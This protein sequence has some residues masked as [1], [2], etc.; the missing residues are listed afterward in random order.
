MAQAPAPSTP[1]VTD[2]VRVTVGTPYHVT[3]E[4]AASRKRL[5]R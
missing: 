4:E 3:A 5:S 2:S 1:A